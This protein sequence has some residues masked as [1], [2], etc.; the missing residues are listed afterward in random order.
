MAR[1][2]VPTSSATARTDAASG[3][4]SSKRRSAAA[5]RAA[6]VVSSC[7]LGRPTVDSVSRRRYDT[8]YRNNVSKRKGETNEREQG[9]DLGDRR[10]R[11]DGPPGGG[12]ARGPGSSGSDRDTAQHAALRLV[13]PEHVGAGRRGRR[14]RLRG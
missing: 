3:P 12:A 9:L 2:E 11:Q 10:D 14:V 4:P 5:R 6:R 8:T 7:S 13:G 1:V